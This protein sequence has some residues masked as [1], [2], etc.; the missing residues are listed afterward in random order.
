MPTLNRRHPAA[1]TWTALMLLLATAWLAYLPGLSGGFLFDDFTNLDALGRRGPIDDWPAFWR[2]VTSGTADPTGRPLALLSFLI[3]AR[4]WP[5]DPSSFLRTNLLLHLLNGVLLFTLLRRLGQH[6]D[7]VGTHTDTA[8]LLGTALWLL[9]PLLVSTTLY[10]VQR[11]AMLPATFVLLGLLAWIYG[12]QLHATQPRAG[13]AWM[14]AGIVAGMVLAA[15]SKANGILLPLLALV[16]ETTVLR[17]G[18]GAK[19]NEVAHQLRWWRRA[20]LVLPSLLLAGWLLQRLPGLQDEL[21]WR[22]WTLAE[23]LLTQPRVLLDYLY[24]LLVP[25]VLSTG[26]YN[27]AYVVS[28]SFMHPASTLPALLAV[29]ALLGLGLS[30]RRHLPVLSAGLLF[31]FAGHLLESSVV[32]LELYFEHRN[33]L[34]AMLLFWPIARALCHWRVT[35]ALRI[36]LAFALTALLAAATWQ[37]ATLWGQPQQLAWLWAQQNPDSPRSQATA[38]QVL[39]EAG[40]YREALV[41]LDQ[42]WRIRPY[43]PQ[44]A[45]NYVNSRCLSGGLTPQDVDAVAITLRH[46]SEG[47]L[48]VHK[49]LSRASATAAEGTCRGIDLDVVERWLDAAWANPVLA[50]PA[51]RQ[52][53][54]LPLQGELAVRRGEPD[55]ALRLFREAIIAFPNPDFAA[56]MTT[57]L[58]IHGYPQHA[59][60]LLDGYTRAGMPRPRRRG[61]AWLHA[62]VLEKQ[63]FWEHEFAVLRG[64]LLEDIAVRRDDAGANVRLG[65]SPRPEQAP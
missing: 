16:L 3:D 11:E 60:E 39:T 8:A 19:A 55:A 57:F 1:T 36:T 44:L 56:R 34:P 27:D 65:E 7:G 40:R 4:D 47:H 64:K 62:H 42:A 45:F 43:E 38:A 25:R 31:W 9:H 53:N 26:L 46:A 15:L 2:Y 13:A 49:W 5:A 61:M 52:Q 37:R 28:T 29:T 32:P 48:L 50:R 14:L 30:L 12:R 22:P 21:A 41:L 35:P 20:L 59:L 51:E 23:R 24:L 33:Y 58:A 18:D 17:A 6:V 63:G 10:I 54:L